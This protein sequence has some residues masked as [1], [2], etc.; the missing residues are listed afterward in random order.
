MVKINSNT[1]ELTR[2]RVYN[3]YFEN[4]IFGKNYTVKH[5][6]RENIPEFTVYI[7][8]IIQRAEKGFGPIRKPGSGRFAKKIT[9][10]NI[11]KLKAM[12]DH[13]DGVTQAQAANKFKCHQSFITK[14]LARHIDIQC[15]KK[16][17]PMRTEAQK[18]TIRAK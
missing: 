12:F 16:K 6:I 4:R 18:A 14:T 11:T 13:K 9:K 17:I 8:Y 7:V 10:S 15:R 5:F 3:F 1:Q 2:Q